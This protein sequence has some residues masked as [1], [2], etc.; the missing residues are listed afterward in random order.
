MSKRDPEELITLLEAAR[1]L[2]LHPETLRRW[3]R[4]NRIEA[5]RFPKEWRF[6]WGTI[7]A[8]LDH[9]LPPRRKTRKSGGAV[10]GKSPT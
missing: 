4:E 7:Q 8:V 1:I 9:G 5:I 6:K 3:A 2:K 10:C